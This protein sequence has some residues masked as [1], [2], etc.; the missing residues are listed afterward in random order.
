[1]KRNT[2]RWTISRYLRGRQ[3]YKI[4]N[5]LFKQDIR[6][7]F[8]MSDIKEALFYRRL[9]DNLVQCFSCAHKCIIRNGERGICRVHKN[10][11][12]KLYLLVYGRLS[13]MAID[14]IEKKPLFHWYPGSPTFSIST[15][16]CNFK[17]PWC[18][19]WDIS[20]ADPDNVKL[21]YVSPEDVVRLAKKYSCPSISITYNEPTIWLEYVLDVSKL[22][23]KDNIKIV[24]VTNG[25]FSEE[26]FNEM[27]KYFHAANIDVKAFREETYKKY[28]GARLQPVLDSI[29]AMKEKKIHVETTYLIIPG[30]NDSE[31]EIRSMVK[32]HIDNLGP[33]TPLHLS[34]FYPHYKFMDRSPTPIETIERAYRIAREEGLRYIYVGNVF[35]H[36]GE[37]TYCPNC[38][39]PVIKRIGFEIVEYNL[40]EDNRCKYCSTKISIVGKYSRSSSW[41]SMFYI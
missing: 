29:I 25:Y 32:W 19:N 11:N 38:G 28:I 6:D 18:Q 7:G 26:S 40:D 4:D 36:K 13:A 16:G 24:L 35:G 5:I 3:K 20:Q 31:E 27:Y 10:I 17:C 34:R 9:K 8:Y 30:L 33:D 12:G 39:K 1:M 41:N 21:R 14:P 15:I 37:Y 2:R 23:S 22:A